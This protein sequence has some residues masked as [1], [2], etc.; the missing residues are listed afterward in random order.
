MGTRPEHGDCTVMIEAR[1][2][3]AELIDTASREV[4]QTLRGF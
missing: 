1:Q 2:P 4:W 3:H